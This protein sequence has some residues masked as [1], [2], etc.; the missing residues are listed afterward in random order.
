LDHHLGGKPATHLDAGFLRAG[1]SSAHLWNQSL[2]EVATVSLGGKQV[3]LVISN[4]YGTTPLELGA[5]HVALAG[6]NESTEGGSDHAVTFD[7]KPG[8]TVPPGAEWISD[9]V[10][11]AVPPL[12]KLAVSLYFPGVVPVTTSHWE[13]RDTAY[14]SEGNTVADSS[15][16][17]G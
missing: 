10:N 6:A 4:L 5:A 3:R 16:N 1:K 14:I 13:G 12:S 7:G 15:I 8:I 11:F 17:H 9:P 2:R